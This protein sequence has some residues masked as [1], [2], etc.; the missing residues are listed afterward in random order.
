MRKGRFTGAEKGTEMV[1]SPEPT[2]ARFFW[3][4]LGN[5]TRSCVEASPSAPATADKGPCY[6]EFRAVGGAKLIT[7]DVRIIAA[8][9]RDLQREMKENRFREDLYYRLA[10]ITLHLPRCGE[11]RS[12]IP[13]LAAEFLVRINKDF[14]GQE[15]GYIHKRILV[16]QMSL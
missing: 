15:P 16:P 13:L 3:M 11:R 9:N 2:A 4:R 7:S 6:R 1:L 14:E 12:D 10:V 8:T 5:V